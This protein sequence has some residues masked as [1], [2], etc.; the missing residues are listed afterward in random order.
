MSVSKCVYVSVY[1]ITL[2]GPTEF[3]MSRRRCGRG[4]SRSMVSLLRQ[5][6]LLLLAT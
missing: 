6:V 2:L 4:A 1:Y 3:S 5:Q